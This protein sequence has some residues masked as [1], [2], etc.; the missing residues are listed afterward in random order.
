MNGLSAEYRAQKWNESDTGKMI[1]KKRILDLFISG[2]V[3]VIFAPILITL[4][5]LVRWRLGSPVLFKQIRPGL[6][7]RPFTIYKFRSMV[8]AHD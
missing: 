6:H 5:L 4:A 2:F 3:L 7:G 8:D 1:L